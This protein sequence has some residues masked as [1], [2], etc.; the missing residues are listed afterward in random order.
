LQLKVDLHVHTTASPDGISNLQNMVNSASQRGLDGIAITDHD[1]TFT[2]KTAQG[3]AVPSGFFLIPGV[4]VSTSS[5][6]LLVLDPRHSFVSGMPFFDVVKT[7]LADGSVPIVPHPT[8]PFSHGV[9]ESIVRSSQPFHLPLEVLN[10]S[11]LRHYNRGA[12]KLADALSLPKVGGSDAHI[13]K[14]VGDAYTIIDSDQRSVTAILDAIK[15]GSTLPAGRQ[16]PI[17]TTASGVFKRFTA[18]IRHKNA[19]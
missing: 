3:I 8:D 18:H 17:S 16:T 11:T 9:G 19:L 13:D 2:E 12:L 14:A 5:G 15:T 10:A 4:E 7:A 6:H 1:R